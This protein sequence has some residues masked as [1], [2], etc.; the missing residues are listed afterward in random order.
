MKRFMCW[1]L[2]CLAALL[3]Y[4]AGAA[5]AED[6]GWTLAKDEDGVQVYTREVAGSQFKE[7]RATTLV[8]APLAAVIAWYG[9]PSTYPEWIESCVEARRVE[10]EAGAA[11][12]LKFDFPFPASNRD[13]VLRGRPL[14][15]TPETVVVEVRNVDGLVAE[16][17]GLVRIPML[18]SRW[19]FRSRGDAE[20]EV[21]YRQHMEAGGRLP[22]FIVNRA[23]VDNPYKTL[24]GLT[25]YAER[26][27]SR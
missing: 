21:I 18:R 17:S 15:E 23:A 22:A 10:D 2:A 4:A 26:Q 9:D 7:F 5:N 27:R 25:R 24:R 16:T 12:Y 11:N 8:P 13:V 19:E 3:A 6:D 20:T 14:E 1:R